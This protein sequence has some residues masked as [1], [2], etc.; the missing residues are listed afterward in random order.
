MVLARLLH[1]DLAGEDTWE[2]RDTLI[3][4][5]MTDQ[6]SPVPNKSLLKSKGTVV[7]L[8]A[9][10][11]RCSS[12]EELPKCIEHIRG[13]ISAWGT[14][15]QSLSVAMAEVMKAVRDVTKKR[16]RKEKEDEAKKK[17]AEAKAS[18]KTK[19][20]APAKP[21]TGDHIFV[22]VFG[23]LPAVEKVTETDADSFFHHFNASVPRCVVVGMV[24][25]AKIVA[26]PF[27]DARVAIFVDQF[28]SSS[29][30]VNTG[31]AFMKM[32]SDKALVK[33]SNH[34]A[35]LSSTSRP[36]RLSEDNE[37]LLSA[38]G[39]VGVAP[40]RTNFHLLELAS[41]RHAFGSNKLNIIV[42][43]L[44]GFIKMCQDIDARFALLSTFFLSCFWLQC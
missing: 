29:A 16:K 26:E 18:A 8:Q 11:K 28:P 21:H 12:I 23:K 33:L 34:Y 31:R 37:K 13:C 43:P 42:M 7:E 22:D 30:A 25:P 20:A 36:H 6:V 15:S 38:P 5:S 9:Q 14:L 35:K 4:Q 41:F 44:D 19:A 10:L 32:G 39:M 2:A 1:D 3:Q 24:E 27:F 17:K 40:G